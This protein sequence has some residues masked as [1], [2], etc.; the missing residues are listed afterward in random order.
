MK[1]PTPPRPDPG[2][3]VTWPDEFGKTQVGILAEVL[4][5]GLTFGAR[6]KPDY[7]RVCLEVA[8]VSEKRKGYWLPLA[9]VRLVDNP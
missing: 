2:D 5:F 7:A 9:L 3:R 6:P 4:E 1:K 8:E